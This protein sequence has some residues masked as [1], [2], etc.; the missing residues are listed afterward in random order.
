MRKGINKGKIEVAKELKEDGVPI[1]K[2]M[3]YTDLSRKEI[4]EL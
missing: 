1:E 2:I 4:E 3:Q